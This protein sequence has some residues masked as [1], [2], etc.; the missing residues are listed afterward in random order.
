MRYQRWLAP[1]VSQLYGA[2]FEGGLQLTRTRTRTLP[3]GWVTF[4]F[5]SHPL[6][7]SAI[8]RSACWIAHGGSDTQF[9]TICDLENEA[10]GASDG[11][12]LALPNNSG[13]ELLQPWDS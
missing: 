3:T 7:L 5:S 11:S 6:V 13:C 2:V 9:Q 4:E 8:D 1:R 12:W 10:S